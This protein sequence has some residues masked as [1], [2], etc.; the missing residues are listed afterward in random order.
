MKTVY[1][2]RHGEC[3]ENLKPVFAGDCESP[4]TDKGKQQAHGFA[5][6]ISDELGDLAPTAFISSPLSRAVN[7]AKVAMEEIED[8]D[9]VEYYFAPDMS[10]GFK[11]EEYFYTVSDL[12]R[13]RNYG[14]IKGRDYHDPELGF[15][16][17]E[18]DELR[19]GFKA[20]VPIKGLDDAETMQQR[21]DEFAKRLLET[22]DD[23]DVV[24]VSCH[25]STGKFLVHALTGREDYL[26]LFHDN[27]SYEKIEIAA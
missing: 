11:N 2:V 6:R 12:L 3:E 19:F 8:K 15:T 7:T 14:E 4:L 20:I 26:D 23:G 21:S 24:V 22:M 5:H 25:K 9:H 18:I 17:E 1:V 27:C 10:A 16:D 13:P